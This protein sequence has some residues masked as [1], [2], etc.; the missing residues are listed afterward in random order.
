MISPTNEFVL[1]AVWL[2]FGLCAPAYLA[3]YFHDRLRSKLKA[4]ALSVFLM[5]MTAASLGA[6]VVMF[7]VHIGIKLGQTF[8]VTSIAFAQAA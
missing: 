5:L 4:I 2:L 6:F 7:A 1:F 3:I 8:A